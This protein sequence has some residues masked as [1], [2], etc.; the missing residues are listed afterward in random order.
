LADVFYARLWVRGAGGEVV[1]F[2]CRPS[3]GIAMGLRAGAPVWVNA[4]L[5]GKWGVAREAVAAEVVAGEAVRYEY[6]EGQKSAS[7]VAAEAR[8]SPELMRVA[9]VK[10][11]LDLAVRLER[12]AEAA[13]LRDELDRMCPIDRLT[14][15]MEKAV[16]EE[17]FLDAAGL[18]DEV[19]E[20]KIRMLQWKLAEKKPPKR[21]RAKKSEKKEK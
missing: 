1:E 4:A 21:R 13:E 8:M 17:R 19:L 20:W 9:K 6:S 12:F 15:E 11:Q 3:D 16:E 7:S 5:L 18:R 10:M 14:K 2:D